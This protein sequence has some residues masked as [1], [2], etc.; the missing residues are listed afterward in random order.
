MNKLI[1][2]LIMTITLIITGCISYTPSPP[3]YDH[4]AVLEGEYEDCLAMPSA[5]CSNER[6]RL[7]QH[8]QWELLDRSS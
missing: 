7:L 2:T 8:Q 1:A 6:D 3:K 4:E 5:D